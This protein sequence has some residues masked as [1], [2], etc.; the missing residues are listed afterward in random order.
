MIWKII[1]A[2]LSSEKVDNCIL[3]SLF[4]PELISLLWLPIMSC[5]LMASAVA[6][7]HCATEP[8]TGWV[9]VLCVTS[10]DTAATT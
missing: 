4:S 2:K 5:M 3:K 8:G 10:V 6:G 7:P 9:S 1:V